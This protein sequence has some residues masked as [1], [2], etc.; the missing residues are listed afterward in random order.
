MAAA[1]RRLAE[2]RSLVEEMGKAASNAARKHTWDQKAL[3]VL[4]YY[5]EVTRARRPVSSSGDAGHRS[6]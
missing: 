6:S 4:A 1:I 3:S 2:D 5:D